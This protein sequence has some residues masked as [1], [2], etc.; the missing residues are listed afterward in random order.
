MG[1]RIRCV[2]GMIA[3]YLIIQAC[4]G[5]EKVVIVVIDV[6]A[7]FGSRIPVG[8]ILQLIVDMAVLQIDVGIERTGDIVLHFAVDIAIYLFGVVAVVFEIG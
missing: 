3:I 1:Y 8:G 2:Y 6:F 4:F 5:V 7:A